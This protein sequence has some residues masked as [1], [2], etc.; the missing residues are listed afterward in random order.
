MNQLIN[1]IKN[2]LSLL[3]SFL[4]GG[5]L[6]LFWLIGLNDN[7]FK[8][9]LYCYLTYIIVF[10]ST[11]IIR[12]IKSGRFGVDILAI[13]AIVSCIFTDDMVAAYIIGLMVSSGEALETLAGQRAK[14]ELSALIKRQ[15]TRVHLVS[16]DDVVEV[17]LDKLKVGDIVLVK[18]NEVVPIDGRLIDQAAVMDES[19]LTGE[20]T[21]VSKVSGDQLISGTVNLKNSISIKA[22]TN[23]NNSY[24]AQLIRYVKSMEEQPSRFVSL[25]N[26]YAVAFTIISLV[27]AVTSWIISSNVQRLTQ[28]LVVASPC[29]LLLAAPIAFVSGMAKCSKNGII[30]KSGSALELTA[31]ADTF[32]F[33]KTGTITDSQITVSRIESTSDYTRTDLLSIAAA[34]ELA[35]THVLATCLVNYAKSKNIKPANITSI[36]EVTGRGLFARLGRKRIVLGSLSF[37]A[38]NKITGLPNSGDQLATYVAVNGKLAGIIYFTETIRPG[39]NN[40]IRKLRSLGVKHCLIL[41]GD[42]HESALRVGQQ[43]QVTKVFSEL[44]P[45]DKV[46]VVRQYQANSHWVVMVGDG[47]NDAPVLAAADVG[48]AVCAMEATVASDTADVVISGNRVNRIYRLRQIARQTLSIAQ[49]SILIGVFLCLILELV[50]AFGYLPA[51]YGAISQEVIDLL[52]IANAL[53]AL[54]WFV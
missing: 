6:L 49:Q 4:V 45:Q 1:T 32:A 5:S 44:E 51:M 19:S 10:K 33:D 24:Y 40:T 17:E 48:I 25:S 27:I 42:R 8:G 52:A 26:R 9:V 20:S 47:I 7:W 39:I 12:T 11:E 15:P 35:S 29:P 37:L 50:A 2:Y 36:R 38:S 18:A 46:A 13:M 14:R 16:N 22:T 23:A 28:V 3:V 21:P 53:R 31:I 54:R 43:I 34:I 41:T 30:V